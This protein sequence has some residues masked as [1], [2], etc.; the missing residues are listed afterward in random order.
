MRKNGNNKEKSSEFTGF[1]TEDLYGE[2]FREINEVL[3]HEVEELG[4]SHILG[5]IKDHYA[6]GI[7]TEKGMDAILPFLERLHEEGFNEC[8][9][10]CGS[11][12]DLFS[13]YP[14]FEPDVPGYTVD[15][16]TFKGKDIKVLCDLG[17]EGRLVAYR[18]GCYKFETLGLVEFA[19]AGIKKDVASS[20]A[21]AEFEMAGSFPG[22]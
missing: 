15:K 20:E 6:P 3:T 21:P 22:I 19:A 9:W 11:I 14:P 2:G 12:K 13:S 8:I 16:Y 18:E 17:S 5:F 1:R 10:L 4:N 7:E